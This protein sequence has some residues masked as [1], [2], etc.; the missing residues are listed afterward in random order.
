MIPAESLR[1][2][3][4]VEA[5]FTTRLGGVSRGPFESFN[6]A[7]GFG[8]DPGAVSLNRRRLCDRLGTEPACLAEAEQ[9]HGTAVAV[10]EAGS[11]AAARSACEVPA[12]RAPGADALLTNRRGVWL[13]IYAA[14]CVPVLIADPRT[15]AVAAVHAGW[16]GTAKNIAGTTLA[17]MHEAFGTDPAD[18]VAELGPAIGGCCYEVDAVVARAMA[19]APWWPAAARATGPDR[20]HLDLRVAVR[21]Q[22]VAAGV[23]DRQIA[24]VPYCTACRPDLFFSYR[25]DGTTGRMA[26]CI[27]IRAAAGQ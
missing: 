2:T 9:V 11:G 24:T 8:D 10:L 21:R 4:I 26:A 25:R 1:R 7:H 3:G 22:L 12:R 5:M 6:L 19:A 18:C 16:R 20:W 14:D 13:V 17:R 15:P 23:P 27:A